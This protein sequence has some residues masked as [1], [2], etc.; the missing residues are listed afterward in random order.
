MA[1]LLLTTGCNLACSY[2]FAREKMM[3]K[4]RQHMS[5]ENVRKVIDFLKRSGYPLFRAMG[6]EPTLHPRFAEIISLALAEGMRVDVLSNATWR[7]SCVDLFARIP[8]GRLNFLINIDHPDNYLPRQWARIERNL[9]ALPERRKLTLSFNIFE[10]AP[11]YEYI[12]D[13][14]RRY[15]IRSVRM[16]FSLPVLG[17]DNQF[18]ELEEYR[19]VVP[20]IMEFVTRAE[21]EGV[22]VRMDNAVPLC[23]FSPEQTG[24]LILDG[25]L[26]LEHNSYCEPIVDI[27]PDLT[28]WCCF[29]LSKL[30]NRKLDEFEDLHQIDAYYRRIL[31]RYQEHLVPWEECRECRYRKLWRCQGGCITHSLM[32]AEKH[33]PDGELP[34]PTPESWDP[35]AVLALADDVEIQRYEIPAECYVLANPE[36]GI[37]IELR[38]SLFEPMASLLDGAYTARQIEHRCV[39]GNGQPADD[40]VEA[41][42]R[43]VEADGYHELLRG[44]LE[45]GFLSRHSPP[46]VEQG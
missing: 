20:F 14:T 40:P 32:K 1:N 17:A 8:P 5:M 16:S 41:F 7:R 24:Q 37:E 15:G 6:G 44:L 12:F 29:C 42:A 22:S 21:S 18:L 3:G 2:C 25:V 46:V 45:R 30:Y 23:I 10:R 33:Y 35:D 39:A 19:T 27:G 11:R 38:S 34:E 28:V 43:G 9:E 36:T 4:R 13:L 26:R 31:H